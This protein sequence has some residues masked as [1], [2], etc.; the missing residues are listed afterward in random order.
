M[1]IPSSHPVKVG[2]WRRISQRLAPN[3]AFFLGGTSHRSL[4]GSNY[5]YIVLHIYIYICVYIYMVLCLV[6]SPHHITR[7]KY[8]DICILYTFAHTHTTYACTHTHMCVCIYNLHI[9]IG[10]VTISGTTRRWAIYIYIYTYIYMGW[11]SIGWYLYQSI[12]DLMSNTVGWW[13]QTCFIYDWSWYRGASPQL[14]STAVVVRKLHGEIHW[15]RYT[16][17]IFVP[18]WYPI[19]GL[20]P[21]SNPWGA[22][23]YPTRPRAGRCQRFPNL[24]MC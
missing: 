16:S 14:A 8:I 23:S 17:P 12:K 6:S 4:V 1:V 22:S 24:T 15:V 2:S 3:H 11:S 18:Y 13:L 21:L 5:I 10:T 20:Y 9:H 19:F 7:D